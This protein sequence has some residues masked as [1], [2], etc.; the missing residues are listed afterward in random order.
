MSPL[1][2]PVDP[3]GLSP[4]VLA[5]TAGVTAG[6]ALVTGSLTVSEQRR[7]SVA[8]EQEVHR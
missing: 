7:R 4:A 3:D 8:A 6:A 1:P 2:V 5:R